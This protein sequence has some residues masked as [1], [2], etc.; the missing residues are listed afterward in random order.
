MFEVTG[1][2]L[3]VFVVLGFV[4]GVFTSFYLTRLIEVV[5]MWRMF[6]QVLIHL[7]IMCLSIVEDLAILRTLK[8]K[9]MVAA[10]LSEEQIV[11]FEEVDERTLT[12]WKESVIL[13]LVNKAPPPF[14]SM[15]PFSDWNEA[16]AFADS[17]L[18]S[19]TNRK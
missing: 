10:Q 12:N 17:E 5:H 11:A 9:Q 16:M 7:L 14:I 18:K 2:E 8:R 1:N 4:A 13:S 19:L 6:R 15:M 3:M